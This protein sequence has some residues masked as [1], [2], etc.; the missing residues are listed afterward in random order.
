MAT[1]A[2]PAHT[3]AT[4]E[5]PLRVLVIDDDK[6]L[7]EAIAESLERKGHKC[8]VATSG[9]AGAGR[10][11]HDEFDVVL[12]DLRMA[13]VDGLG[14]VK[15]VREH[16]PDAE[17]YVIT[18]Y[19]DVKTAVEAMRLGAAHYLLKPIDMVELRAI[20]DKSAERVKLSRANR[21]LRPGDARRNAA[22]LPAGEKLTPKDWGPGTVH[23]DAVDATGNAYTTGETG[24]SDFPITPDALWNGGGS[25]LAKL[26][27]IHFGNSGRK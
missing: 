17:V 1:A 20:V 26:D 24:S 25:F 10:V 21:E 23:V 27:F 5:E 2:L 3:P 12:T 6:N 9:K 22:L 4:S 16:L 8:T 14:M 11:E 19:G 7:A 15:K 18:G 13:D